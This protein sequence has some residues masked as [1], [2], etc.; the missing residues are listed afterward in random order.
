MVGKGLEGLP[1]GLS[2]QY[3]PAEF[4]KTLMGIT[5]KHQAPVLVFSHSMKSQ[6]QML[7]ISMSESWEL[8]S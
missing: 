1:S 4:L 2:E 8:W 3:L 5:E 7:D 6:L